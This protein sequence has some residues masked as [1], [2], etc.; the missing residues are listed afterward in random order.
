MDIFHFAG[1]TFLLM[2]DAYSNYPL[3]KKFGKASSTDKVIKTLSKWFDTFGYPL[4]AR[5]DGG[6]GFCTWFKE[7]LTQVGIRC[8]LSSSYNL[9]SN[10]RAERSVGQ[11]KELMRR[12]KESK[13]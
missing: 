7:Y 11:I 8:E 5:H 6:P 9:P 2:V 1:N 10:R 3:V 12:T 13:E 4:Y